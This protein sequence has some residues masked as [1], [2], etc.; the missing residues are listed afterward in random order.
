M[1]DGV[2]DAGVDLLCERVAITGIHLASS[3]SGR[4][5]KVGG[6]NYGEGIVS[7]TILVERDI[8][9][10]NVVA[11][12]AGYTGAV[13]VNGVGVCEYRVIGLLN[14]EQRNVLE[15]LTVVEA[16]TATENE[17]AVAENVDGN[18]DARAEIKS[19]VVRKRVIGAAEVSEAG[20][21]ADPVLVG[22]RGG[23]RDKAGFVGG[24]HLLIRAAVLLLRDAVGVDVFVVAQAEVEKQ[25]TVHAPIILAVEADHLGREIEAGVA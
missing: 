10:G 23:H 4:E 8:C 9:S 16:V 6:R 19:I 11:G 5:V 21:V 15:G 12:L 17:F 20:S 3:G 14:H 7:V 22:T 25:M 18:A 24:D 1:S 13:A 2:L